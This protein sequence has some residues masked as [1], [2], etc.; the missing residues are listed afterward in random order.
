MKNNKH[1][2]LL[3]WLTLFSVYLYTLS[4]KNIHHQVLIKD[5]PLLESK[6]EE[7]SALNYLNQ[8][9]K[10]AGLIEFNSNKQLTNAARNHAHY[11]TE[12]HTFGHFEAKN[13]RAFTGTYASDRILYAGYATPL[14]I[15][16]VSSNNRNY[17][18]SIDGLFSAIYHRIAFLDFQSDTIGI[19]IMQ[20]QKDKFKTSFVYNMSAKALE[21]IYKAKK[22]NHPKKLHIPKS[23]LNKALTTHKNNNAK[24]VLYPFDNQSDIPPAFFDEIPDPLPDYGVSGFP[25]SISLNPVH[26]KEVKLLKFE[27][28][29][30]EG[31]RIKESLIYDHKSDP[32][33]RL[34][35]FDFVLFPLKRLEW[36]TQYH[37]KFSAIVDHKKIE[38]K[39]SF[40][41]R[42]FNLPFH[43][44]SNK[45]KTFTIKQGQTHIF[46][47]PP[48]S[49]V[50][51]LVDLKYPSTFDIDFV[52]QNTITLIALEAIELPVTLNIGK[53]H[54]KLQIEP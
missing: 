6:K 51:L 34:N 12:Q 5:A 42:A 29:N 43:Q 27:L 50:D 48:S 32:H 35:R 4:A 23:V 3:G 25:I 9:R 20:N 45:E 14:V 22:S 52:D 1:T 46:Y 30:S 47:F 40:Q 31:R 21:K 7:Q 2:F 38:K 18:E 39:W 26:F 24:V 54:L 33:K 49:K 44:V 8:L 37:V 17:K 36:N 11:L 16:N 13:K 53:H 10:G 19:G 15:E 41:T 28:F